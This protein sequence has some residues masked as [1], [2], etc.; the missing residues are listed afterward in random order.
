[1]SGEAPRLRTRRL[2]VPNGT[3]LLIACSGGRLSGRTALLE[4]LDA[5]YAA[6]LPR[7]LADLGRADFGRPELALAADDENPARRN[8]SHASDLLFH[9]R[10]ELSRRAKEFGKG[11][12]FPRLTQGL[13]AVTGWQ[14]PGAGE[15]DAA[16]RRLE[17]LLRESLPAGRE[18]Q[19]RVTR[20]TREA[21]AGR[22]AAPGP[23]AGANELVA[24]LVDVVGPDLLG[25]LAHNHGLRWWA[26]RPL[27]GQDD[28][29]VRL[30]ELARLFRGDP[31]DREVAEGH[32]MA[33]LLADIDAHYTLT[34]RLNR[35]P[36]PLLLLDNAHTPLGGPVLRT[37]ARVWHEE[38]DG[39]RPGVVTTLLAEE[40]PAA[41]PESVAPSTRRAAGPFWRPG[42]PATAAGWIL[43]LPLSRLDLGE[44][45]RMFG[46]EHPPP[47]TARVIHRLSAG[48][49]GIAH[50]LV[51]AGRLA[52]LQGDNADPRFLLDLPAHDAPGTAVHERLLRVLVPDSLNLDRLAHFSPALD[53]EAADLLGEN[54]PPGDP[55]TLGVQ[56]VK[57]LLERN[58]WGGGGGGAGQGFDGPFVKDPTLRA[59]LGHHLAVRLGREADMRTWRH[60]HGTL[61]ARY[62]PDATGLP[63]QALHHALAVL[64]TGAVVRT[65]HQ[66]LAQR[67]AADWLASV[68][69]VCTAPHPPRPLPS[70][71]GPNEPCPACE[72]GN[73]PVHR[74]V[75]L[76]VRNLW[77]QSH[78]LAV[79]A[80]EPIDAVRLQLLTLAQH[81]G[82]AD[83]AVFFRAH[84]TWPDLL[85]DRWYQAP[86][87]PIRGDSRP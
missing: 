47:G 49:A 1:M 74:A 29:H 79:P 25:P 9:L 13:L 36:R 28:A 4:A 70:A 39:R 60:L 44:V 80:R 75:D 8:A 7:A 64:D 16:A 62:A 6:Y 20:W 18:R 37:L 73:D 31:D 14:S 30:T 12:A 11:I 40:S 17:S 82:A 48:R 86:H 23:G 81:T 65:L 22:G 50:A 72:G 78:P 43:R 33:A 61:R 10:H 38:P 83:Q 84:E 52:L 35:L 3:P 87:L 46:T 32:L 24:R 57:R 26:A 67:S 69:L 54:Y 45:N 27:T 53:D 15:L 55:G 59:L 34:R 66:R 19:D 56:E 2:P 21:E 5:R 41:D 51:Q 42:P 58:H 76:L 85:R 63:D 68:N 71:A 77:V